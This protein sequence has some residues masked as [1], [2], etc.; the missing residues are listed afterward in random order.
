M[1]SL[2]WAIGRVLHATGYTTKYG[3]HGLGFGLALLSCALA[4][5]LLL[6][7]AFATFVAR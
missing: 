5:G 1:L 6:V 3:A 2:V 4:E 7:A